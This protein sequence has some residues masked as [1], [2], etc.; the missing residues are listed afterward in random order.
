M[1]SGSGS[2]SGNR[3]GDTPIPPRRSISRNSITG[4]G[5]MSEQVLNLPVQPDN[6]GFDDVAYHEFLQR[7]AYFQSLNYPVNPNP[8]LI[9]SEPEASHPSGSAPS[10]N[11]TSQSEN[12]PDHPPDPDFEVPPTEEILE[13]A[14]KQPKSDLFVYHM[15]KIAKEDGTMTVICNYCHKVFKWSKSGGYEIDV[16]IHSYCYTIKTLLYELYDEYRRVYGPSLNI[17]VPQTQTVSN[18]RSSGFLGLGSRLLSQKTKKLRDS[19]FS[20]SSASYSE[21]ETYHNTSFE[22]IGDD[23]EENFDILHWW[24]DHERHFPILAII[25]KQILGTTVS[26]VAVE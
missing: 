17:S 11:I 25:A 18:T 1:A 21:I 19:S 8:P 23:D 26:T 12:M 10:P 5:L 4:K 2:G 6:I 14:E 24:R 20:L 7:Q 16:D 22:F 9:I 13:K 15:K 3:A